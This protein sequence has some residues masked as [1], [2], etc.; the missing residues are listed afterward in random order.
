MWNVERVLCD[1]LWG[2]WVAAMAARP[3]E[4]AVA[5]P[6]RRDGDISAAQ[7]LYPDRS[8]LPGW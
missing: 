6:A 7:R 8:M 1:S 2:V 5:W 3:A 4:A